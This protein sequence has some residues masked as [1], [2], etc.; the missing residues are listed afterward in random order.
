MSKKSLAP[1]NAIEESVAHL[2]V[3][4]L[5]FEEVILLPEGEYDYNNRIQNASRIIAALLKDRLLPDQ[6]G[7]PFEW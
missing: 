3:G 1:G 2:I 7:V 4:C 5:I 6:P